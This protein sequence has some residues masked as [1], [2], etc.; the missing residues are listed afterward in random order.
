MR[1]VAV[2]CGRACFAGRF[3]KPQLDDE[4]MHIRLRQR[5]AALS[6]WLLPRRAGASGLPRR[7]RPEAEIEST[8]GVYQ[9]GRRTSVCRASAQS[10]S[11]RREGGLVTW[12]GHATPTRRAYSRRWRACGGF[13]RWGRSEL[14]R[15]D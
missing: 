10:L 4:R 7:A 9:M 13:S 14:T 2:P 12:H 15:Q 11:P 8:H 3:F 1:D 6:S 5:S